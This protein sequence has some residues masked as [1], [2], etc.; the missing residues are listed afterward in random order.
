MGLVCST[1]CSLPFSRTEAIDSGCGL[2]F[3]KT[4]AIDPACAAPW[5]KT[6]PMDTDCEAPWEKTRPIDVDCE[7]VWQKTRPIDVECETPWSKTTPLDP[8]CLI[9][10]Q[11]TNALDP[12]CPAIFARAE[13]VDSQCTTEFSPE[14]KPW[15]QCEIPYLDLGGRIVIAQEIE[16]Y[17]T[18][19]DQ[20][21]ELVQGSITADRNQWC[22]TFEGVVASRVDANYLRLDSGPV[23][24]ILGINGYYWKIYVEKISDNYAHASST[25]TIQGRSKSIEMSAPYAPQMT[26]TYGSAYTIQQLVADRINT[27]GYSWGQIWGDGA[28]LKN[29]TVPADTYSY[30]NF[31]R[32]AVVQDIC[33][34]IGAF[35]QTEGGTT[36][37]PATIVDRL[38]FNSLYPTSPH[39]WGTATIDEYISPSHIFSQSYFWSPGKGVDYVYI[40]GMGTNAILR[41]MYRLAYAPTTAY[42]TQTNELMCHEDATFQ[43]GRSILDTHQWDKTVHTLMLPLPLASMSIRP[44]LILPG[45]LLEITDLFSTWRGQAISVRIA[46]GQKVGVTQSI[47]VEQFHT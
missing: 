31:T 28:N 43:L 25:Y 46:M 23:E 47:K 45:N 42:P 27:G 38:V 12:V 5:L 19:D 3:A 16:F 2:P 24:C 13:P 22:W 9:P 14:E 39:Q 32:M 41:K 33:K 18:S 44:A 8:V 40:S 36:T 11:K 7:T 37:D 30:A 10:W 15:V 6:Y 29:W 20:P 21:I 35:V 34:K 4:R 1:G 17:R 26:D